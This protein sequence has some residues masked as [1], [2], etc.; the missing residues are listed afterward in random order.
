[1]PRTHV[2]INSVGWAFQ[3]EHPVQVDDRRGGRRPILL[4]LLL[5][6]LRSETEGPKTKRSAG[7]DTDAV[8]VGCAAF[9]DD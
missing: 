6:S 1:M 8:F 7:P 9:V 4:F 3:M 2:K 5:L